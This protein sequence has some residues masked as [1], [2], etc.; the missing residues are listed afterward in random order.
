MCWR[1]KNFWCLNKLIFTK[2]N[3]ASTCSDCCLNCYKRSFPIQKFVYK[4]IS[5]KLLDKRSS[6][7]QKT[8]AK[9]KIVTFLILLNDEIV[10]ENF[11]LSIAST[12]VTNNFEHR[13][14]RWANEKKILPGTEAEV[15]SGQGY[16]TWFISRV[17]QRHIAPMLHSN[18]SVVTSLETASSTVVKTTLCLHILQIYPPMDHF[19]GDAWKIGS[20]QSLYYWCCQE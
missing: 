5:L 12:I 18:T 14:I 9:L 10:L 16:W 6:Y 11:L 17:E 13:A 7:A 3:W 19:C 8:L 15:T 20:K 4:F 2:R 1:N